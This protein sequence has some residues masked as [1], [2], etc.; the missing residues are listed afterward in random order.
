[1]TS[2]SSSNLEYSEEFYHLR[3]RLMEEDIPVFNDDTI[4][5]MKIRY[6]KHSIISDILS[7][8]ELIETSYRQNCNFSRYELNTMTLNDL[9]LLKLQ[10]KEKLL[11]LEL[12]NMLVIGL[13]IVSDNINKPK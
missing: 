2:T 3:D 13:R 12:V 11:R 5:S 10:T 9:N 1:M 4:Q 8:K 6:E 7:M